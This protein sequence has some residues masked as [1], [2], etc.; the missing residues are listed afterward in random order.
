MNWRNF[1][2]SIKYLKKK[3]YHRILHGKSVIKHSTRL[4][5]E[6][7]WPMIFSSL[8]SVW[9]KCKKIH[10]VL[11]VNR[12]WQILMLTCGQMF[13]DEP[14][15]DETL[16]TYI[17]FLKGVGANIHQNSLILALWYF[18]I[19]WKM[20]HPQWVTLCAIFKTIFTQTPFLVHYEH[21][22][23]GLKY[24]KIPGSIRS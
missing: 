24:K 19:D 1:A 13:L 6:I 17:L 14:E 8:M 15:L 10:I 7:E 21:Q 23:Q 2:F 3:Y 16:Y 22:S 5:L 11:T 12:Y 20:I 4:T 18:D 9:H